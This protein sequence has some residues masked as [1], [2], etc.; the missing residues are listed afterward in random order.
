MVFTWVYTGVKN[1]QPVYLR[2]RKFIAYS[3]SAFPDAI[4]LLSELIE[5]IGFG[6]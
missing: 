4:F 1:Y 2:F 6:S 3:T 5:L